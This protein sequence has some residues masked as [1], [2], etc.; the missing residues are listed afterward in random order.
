MD[1]K[2]ITQLE[3]L[4][5]YILAVRP[6]EFGLVL[7]DEGW[8][9][10]KELVRI[11]QEEPLWRFMRLGY[12]K[13]AFSFFPAGRFEIS[14][15]EMM[16]RVAPAIA[17]PVLGREI[18]PPRIV[19][20]AVRRTAYPHILE[21][22]LRPIP[23][24][25]Y[26]VAAVDEKLALRMGKRRDQ[27]PVLIKIDTKAAADQGTSF[28]G[29][30]EQLF[31]LDFLPP[32]SIS[33]PQFKAKVIRPPDRTRKPRPGPEPLSGGGDHAPLAPSPGK[34]SERDKDKMAWKK[35]RKK[36]QKKEWF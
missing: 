25:R 5:F 15:D 31:L 2:Q 19:Y 20:M 3:K 35:E 23:G 34:K 22:G 21:K 4:L 1:K 36:R 16:V 6:D 9:S 29:Y 14:V 27:E 17:A 11:L 33:G 26:L 32:E 28:L 13:E 24:Q 8:V 30:Y 18:M 10:A 12:L 7:D